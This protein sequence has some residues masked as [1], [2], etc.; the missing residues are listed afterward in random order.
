[1]IEDIFKERKHLLDHVLE[2]ISMVQN[3]IAGNILPDI[4]N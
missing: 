4:M 2:N 3:G 1:M